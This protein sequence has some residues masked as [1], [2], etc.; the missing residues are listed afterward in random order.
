MIR[1]YRQCQSVGTPYKR[2]V[3]WRCKVEVETLCRA[4]EKLRGKL[5]I[6]TIVRKK[7]KNVTLYRPWIICKIKFY[8]Q[9][10]N[11]K[12]LIR[13]FRQEF[14]SQDQNVKKDNRLLRLLSKI[15]STVNY[16]RTDHIYKRRPTVLFNSVWTAEFC[17]VWIK[18]C[19]DL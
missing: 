3:R 1:E 9:T 19:Q 10:I 13:Y 8:S 12:N 16:V 4:K 7:K 14:S 6:D 2:Y 5:Q 18:D 15:V 11:A 17:R